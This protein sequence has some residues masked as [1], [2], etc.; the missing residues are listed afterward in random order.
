MPTSGWPAQTY[1]YLGR[2]DKDYAVYFW[3]Y[4][5]SSGTTIAVNNLKL[6]KG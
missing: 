5:E 3:M 4:I 2:P 1:F 6:L